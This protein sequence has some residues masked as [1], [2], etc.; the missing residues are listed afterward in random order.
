[1]LDRTLRAASVALALL[2]PGLVFAEDQ[3]STTTTDVPAT[4]DKILGASG[5]AVSGYL[6]G[7]YKYID[8]TNPSAVR[9]FTTQQNSFTLNQ[10]AL[11][12]AK[13]P[14]EGFGGLIN[15]MAGSD[16]SIFSSYPYNTGPSN[17]QFDVTQAYG[18]YASGPFTVIAGKFTTL[19]SYEVIW[20][21]ANNNTSRSILFGAVPFTHTGVRLT[22]VEN[23]KLTWIGGVNNGWDQVSATTSSKTMELG[24]V[25]T[26]TKAL[27]ITLSDLNG[28]ALSTANAVPTPAQAD[29]KGPYGER[30]SFDAVVT[31]TVSDPLSFGAEYLNVSQD[32]YQAYTGATPVLARYDGFALYA[33]YLFTPQWRLA[34]RGEN[35]QDR[36][37]FH[38]LGTAGCASGG[39]CVDPAQ[40]YAGQST[41]YREFT[42]TLSWLKTEHVELRAEVRGDHASNAVFLESSGTR[43]ST[44]M[45]FAVE[46]LYKF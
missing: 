20:A 11:Q 13:Q 41:T 43:N 2:T 31:Y 46:G 16:A 9:V 45:S 23:D 39:A 37:G 29:A 34:L 24:T 27:S 5:I 14:K 26:P 18:Q 44:M 40:P 15:V 12:I 3:T 30:N 36:N 8:R 7:S 19:Q 22:Y 17:N 38:F 32:N 28:Q 6:D 33:T 25:I 42:A 21:P 4:I 10:A 1:M 35:F